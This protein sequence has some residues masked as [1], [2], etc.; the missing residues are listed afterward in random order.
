MKYAMGVVGLG[1]MGANLARNIESRGFPVVGYDLDAA[2]AQAFVNG[3]AKGKAVAAAD[4]PANL[5]V[6]LEKPRRILVMV[7]AGK[8][9]DSVIAHLKPH[10]EAG[11]IL[12]DG[13]NSLLRRHRSAIGRARLRRLPLRG[14][15]RVWAARRARF[16]DQRS[17]RAARGRRGT[18]SPPSCA[19][20]R[21]RPRTASR[22]SPT[23][24]RAAPGTTS[25]WCTTGSSTA[26]CSSSPRSTTCCSRGGGLSAA[27]IADIFSEWNEAELRSYLIE[28]TAQALRHIDKDTGQPLVDVILDEAQQKGTGKWTSQNSFDL[29]API[30]TINAAVEA[31][32]ISALKAE[33]VAASRVL[34]GPGSAWRSHGRSPGS[35]ST[36]RGTPSTRARS[37]PTRRACR[38]CGWRRPSTSYDIDPGEV[39]KIWRAG[40]IIRAALL[41]DIREAFKR[42]RTSS[43]CSS[44][45]RSA[46]R[47]ASPPSRAAG[48]SSSRP[49]SASAS[50]WPASARRS[51]T[52]MRT[53]ARGSPRTS[54]RRSAISSARTPTGGSTATASSTPTG[55]PTAN[56]APMTKALQ[57]RPDG[58]LDFLSLGALIHRLDPG[59]V[60]FR[61]AQTCAIH[62]SGGEFNTAANLADCFGLRTGIATRDGRLPDRRP[63]RRARPRH[64]REAVLQALQARRRARP[65]H[66]HGLQRSGL[67]RARPDGLL[68]PRQ[69]G[70][71]AA[72]A[73][74]L[75]LGGDLRRRRPLVPLRRHL[76]GALRYDVGADHR[77][78]AGGEGAR[79]GR[80]VRPQLSREAVDRLWQS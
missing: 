60:P 18:R 56:E 8:P 26:T 27:E 45:M 65:E 29:G 50:R 59:V 77:S 35:S 58:A 7:P 6:M 62:V 39:A 52:T 30:P 1:V 66:G 73:R 76:R 69:R 24:G 80:V 43:T 32:Q 71:R 12:I 68:Q 13:G 54:P 70:R 64:G 72:Q 36:P 11:D 5:M 55:P 20:S 4:S 23:W 14:R 49:P 42:T 57:I 46:A 25:R 47:S 10:L 74:R 51:P 3:P 31:R 63:D 33:R 67:R 78:D 34:E 2:K 19:P 44:M 9:V 75:R 41:G 53:G 61:K 21:Q 22:A 16:T 48:G 38:S 79:R 15:R 37:R 40:C 28:I 17:C